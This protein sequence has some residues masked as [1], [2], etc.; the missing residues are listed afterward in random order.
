MCSVPLTSNITP[1]IL[2]RAR[3]DCIVCTRRLYGA[4]VEVKVRAN[5]NRLNGAK[6]IEGAR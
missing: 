4:V 5:W 2:P 6:V 3:V 1:L